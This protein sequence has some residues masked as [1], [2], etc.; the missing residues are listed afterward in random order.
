MW[1]NYVGCQA[2]CTDENCE[3]L[4]SGEG[5]H[6][7]HLKK[8]YGDTYARMVNTATRQFIGNFRKFVKRSSSHDVTVENDGLSS[9]ER[10]D[11]VM[12][13]SRSATN[14]WTLP[15]TKKMFISI[16]E[17]YFRK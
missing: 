7:R 17:R 2:R 14:V 1:F 10:S 5:K 11:T 6:G 15:S 4:F 16:E 12:G 8:E 3:M 13:T 9:G